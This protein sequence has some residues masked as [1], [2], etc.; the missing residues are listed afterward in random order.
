MRETVYSALEFLLV[1]DQDEL[2]VWG[3]VTDA[4]AGRWQGFRS[5]VLGKD[6]LREAYSSWS[7][8]QWPARSA[9]R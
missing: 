9:R 1:F 5:Q 7:D 3:V 4:D 2:R 6:G 8:C